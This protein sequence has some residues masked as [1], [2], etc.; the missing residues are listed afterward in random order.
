MAH[1]ALARPTALAWQV[2]ERKLWLV[3]CLMRKV[4]LMRSRSVARFGSQMLVMKPR[5]RS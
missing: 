3:M 4:L 1:L 5:P 2:K